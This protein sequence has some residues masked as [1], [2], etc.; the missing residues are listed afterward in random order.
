MNNYKIIQEY[1]YKKLIN[2]YIS[3]NKILYKY[4]SYILKRNKDKT[5]IGYQKQRKDLLPQ[6]EI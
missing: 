1:E 4:I 5:I 3:N 6:G 2:K